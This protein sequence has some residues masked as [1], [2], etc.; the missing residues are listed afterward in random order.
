M[1]NEYV[2]ICAC[3]Q[4]R[5]VVVLCGLDVCKTNLFTDD[6]FSAAETFKMD[7]AR[8]ARRG[9]VQTPTPL[10]HLPR[11]SALLGGPNIYMK[12]DDLLPGAAGGNKTRKLDFSDWFHAV[13]C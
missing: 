3:L 12:R 1:K 7:L 2:N 11:L 13:N 4:L 6:D 5:I 10:Q 8:F 9:Y